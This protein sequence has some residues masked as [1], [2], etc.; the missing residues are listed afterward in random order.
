MELLYFWV[1]VAIVFLIVEM[2]TATFY[3]LSLALAS[4]VV[5]VY[6]WYTGEISL[7]IVQGVIFASITFLASYTLPR[8]LVPGSGEPNLQGMETYIGLKRKVKSQGDT[9]KITLDGVDY[10]V[11]GDDIEV[12]K[13]VEIV[14]VHGAGFS[15]KNV[16]K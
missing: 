16:Q 3:G 13:Q 10:I 4:G 14:G 15:V 6:V 9:L 12:G 2:L 11:E 1:A 8:L 7:D 5:A